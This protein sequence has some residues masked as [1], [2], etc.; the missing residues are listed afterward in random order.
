MTDVEDLDDARV[1]HASE[2]L[3]FALEA[4]RAVG[5]LG[6]PRLDHLDR[7]R[8]RQPPVVPAINAA[9]RALADQLVELVAPVERAAGQIGGVRHRLR[10]LA[11]WSSSRLRAALSM[12]ESTP[13]VIILNPAS[14]YRWAA[15]APEQ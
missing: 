9:E 7:D 11:R 3:G 5:I 14:A 2:Q 4:L 8:A 12:L 13:T 15:R 6:P 10:P 1:A